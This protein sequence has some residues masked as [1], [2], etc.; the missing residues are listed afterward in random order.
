MCACCVGC[1]C[2]HVYACCTDLTG[3]CAVWG[4]EADGGGARRVVAVQLMEHLQHARSGGRER[5]DVTV[6]VVIRAEQGV[7]ARS[8]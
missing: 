5:E 2:V 3:G 1:A 4:S 8:F 6:V 7:H